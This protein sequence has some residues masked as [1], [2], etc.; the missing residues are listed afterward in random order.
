MGMELFDTTGRLP[1]ILT[2]G[3]EKC[4]PKGREMAKLVY[5]ELNET[6]LH[7]VIK[8]WSLP[9]TGKFWSKAQTPSRLLQFE[10]T[11]NTVAKGCMSIS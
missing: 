2:E 4:K 7:E 5:Q 1:E 10:N 3:S 11:L 6:V 8:H 9:E